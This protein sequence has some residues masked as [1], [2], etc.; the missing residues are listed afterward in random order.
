M[1]TGSGVSVPPM[2]SRRK[3]ALHG[4]ACSDGSLCFEGKR[5]TGGNRWRFE[6]AEPD[7][8][9]R[10][11]FAE[12]VHDLY[13]VESRDMP[14]Y[15]VIRAFG[16][17]MLLDLKQYGPYGKLRWRV[18]IRY[19]KR[20][21]AKEWLRAYFD[22]DGD[23]RVSKGLSKCMVRARSVNKEG[24]M[25]VQLVLMRFF[26]IEAKLY[27]H[28]KP[29]LPTWSQSYDLDV[30]GMRN[31]REFARLVGFNHPD[32]SRKLDDISRLVE[33]RDLKKRSY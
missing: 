22:G 7:A 2:L 3:A 11:R 5:R 12:L 16:K 32:K 17:E 25:D 1:D 21:S 8:T 33:Q 10:A 13:G 18:P 24:L 9:I 26:Q 20:R 19:L 28:G 6:L 30:I 15:G 29:K 23:V 4:M 31:L 27:L 14:D